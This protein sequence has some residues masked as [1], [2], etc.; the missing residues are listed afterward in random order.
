MLKFTKS[1]NFCVLVVL[2]LKV[3][4]TDAMALD[5]DRLYAELE[6]HEDL[7][8]H[9][10]DDATGKRLSAGEKPKGHPTIGIGRNLRARPLSDAEKALLRENR[11]DLGER[12][13][14]K[15]GITEEE[16]WYLVGNDVQA[17]VAEMDKRLPWWRNMTEVRQRALVNMA[18]NMGVDGLLGFK[19]ML[20]AMRAGQFDRAAKEAISSK[21]A[22]QV[23]RR[24][25][26]IA[27]MIQR[28]TA[29]EIRDVQPVQFASEAPEPLDV[30]MPAGM[31]TQQVAALVPEPEIA[32]PLVSTA[33][34]EAGMERE[35]RTPAEVADDIGTE[36]ASGI[37]S[38]QESISLPTKGRPVV[39][40]GQQ[41]LGAEAGVFSGPE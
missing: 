40:S 1:A 30:A 3:I 24:S 2:L 9:V 12:D 7:R 28:D 18:F 17:T 31:A 32:E 14:F 11:P 37:P 34:L 39:P 35:P 13:L 4:G 25:N 15:D 26:D 22:G 5:I 8:T 19:K 21:W 41:P 6:R 36:T 27:R 20:G 29:P 33:A 23:G 10:Y 16:A 38:G